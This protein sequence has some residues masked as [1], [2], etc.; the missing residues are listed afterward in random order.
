MTAS[1]LYRRIFMTSVALGVVI[2]AVGAFAVGSELTISNYVNPDYAHVG[3][4]VTFSAAV[5]NPNDGEAEFTTRFEYPDGSTSVLDSALLLAPGDTRTYTLPYRV[6]GS[7]S[8]GVSTP[9]G[10]EIGAVFTVDGFVYSDQ[11]ES[12]CVEE[13]VDGYAATVCYVL[14]P[15]IDVRTWVDFNHDTSFSDD[16]ETYYAGMADW[17]TTVTNT[18]NCPLTV[19]LV[20]STG[21]DFGGSFTLAAGAS[22]TF[23][24]SSEADDDYTN[25]VEATGVDAIGGDSGTVSDSDPASVVVIAPILTI[26]KSVDFDG[27]GVFSDESETGWIG[28]EADW[29]IVVTNTGRSTLTDL[30]VTDDNGTSWIIGSLAPGA[31]QTYEYTTTVTQSGTNNASATGTDPLGNP[32][33]VTDDASVVAQAVNS[34]ITVSKSVDANGDEVYADDQE[35]GWIGYDAY[36]RIV[37]TNTGDSPLYNVVVTDDNGMSFGPIAVL[38]AGASETYEYDTELVEDVINRAT[39]TA[40]D[41]LGYHLE[42]I[43][44]AKAVAVPEPLPDLAITKSPDDTTPLPGELVD[45]T[46]DFE[47]IGTGAAVGYVIVDDFD[48]RYVTVVDPAGGVVADGK[49]RWE[50][51]E[52]LQ[53]GQGGSI[54]YTVRMVTEDDLDLGTTDVINTVAIS[55]PRDSDESNNTDTSTVVVEN[56]FLPFTPDDP[57]EPDDEPFLPFTGANALLLGAASMLAAVGGVGIRPRRDRKGR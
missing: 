42:D 29:R 27:D 8:G 17:K 50:F 34:E 7:E 18:G 9:Q 53:P 41:V 16:S 39:A 36:W 12:Q 19:T 6:T 52:T 30:V 11:I 32:L 26:V 35:T 31:S 25:T 28:A 15:D 5:G 47:N 38:A 33:T 24:Y 23:E 54:T 43:D 57:E 45:Y 2:L 56:A 49:I 20:D 14:E 13:P 46:L 51:T 1:M 3:D 40:T 48:E 37:V 44:D 4:T 10:R 22:K 21:H 55:T